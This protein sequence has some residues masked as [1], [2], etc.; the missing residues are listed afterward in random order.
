[1]SAVSL[2]LPR[3]PRSASI[4]MAALGPIAIGAILAARVS[5][6]SP[7]FTAPAIV[8]GVFA[9][10]SPAL[11]IATATAGHAPNMG[12]MMRAF[13]VAIGAFG[14]VLAGLVLPT[15]VLSL[16]S[17]VPASTF[18][19]TSVALGGAAVLALRRLAGELELK[20]SVTWA[21]FL[22]WSVATLG[23]AGRLWWDLAREVIS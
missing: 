5:N 17:T 10:T 4:A 18:L 20:G 14:I 1:M 7:L 11:Y 19:V 6:V 3:I 16:T 2:P 8:F 9:I 21:V 12:A 22:V 13:G 23:I 15:A